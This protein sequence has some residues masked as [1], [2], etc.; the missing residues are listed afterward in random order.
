MNLV[1]LTGTRGERLFVNPNHIFAII[2]NTDYRRIISDSD[3]DINV[4]ESMDDIITA[5]QLNSVV[6]GVWYARDGGQEH[7]D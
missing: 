5:I 6:G 1:E 7:R 3:V 4:Q 2:E